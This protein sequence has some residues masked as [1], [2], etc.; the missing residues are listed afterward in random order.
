MQHLEEF[1]IGLK[2]SIYSYLHI[3]FSKD[4]STAEVE[5]LYIPPVEPRLHGQIATPHR[6]NSHTMPEGLTSQYLL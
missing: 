6:T 2:N 1:E 5:Q 4:T 3:P